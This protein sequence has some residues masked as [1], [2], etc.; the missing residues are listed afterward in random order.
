MSGYSGSD[1]R[2]PRSDSSTAS[3]VPS[4][5]T[6]GNAQQPMYNPAVPGYYFVGNNMVGP[7]FPY[8]PPPPMYP[9]TAMVTATNAS[10][11]PHAA[12]GN[13][14]YQTKTVYGSYGYD[15]GQGTGTEYG[16]NSYTGGSGV[17][18]NAN[19]NKGGSGSNPGGSQTTD[20]NSS[21]YGKGH[22]MNKMNVST[23]S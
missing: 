17:G 14:Q 4:N 7:P 11:A 5:L 20:M 13:H 23:C 9:T 10:G 2:F 16:K 8:G 15:S 18:P 6:G 19:S 22:N 3:P 12:T 21:M 1:G